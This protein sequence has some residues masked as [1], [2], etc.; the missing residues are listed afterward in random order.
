[1]CKRST[2]RAAR[3]ARTSSASPTWN[4]LAALPVCCSL[5][6]RTDQVAIADGGRARSAGQFER[7]KHELALLPLRVRGLERVRLPADLTI[8]AKLVCALNRARAVPLAA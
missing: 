6:R 4:P 8:L 2:R 5:G 1:M 7:L 3:G